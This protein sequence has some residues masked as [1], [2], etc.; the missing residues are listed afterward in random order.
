MS[1]EGKLK[2]MNKMKRIF[3]IIFITILPLSL[4]AQAL[5]SIS[6]RVT[7]KK[8]GEVLPGVNVV[9]EKLN[10]GTASMCMAPQQEQ[11]LKGS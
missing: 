8:T 11:C 10:L 5:G 9:I 3:L 4:W 1:A 6:G 2:T 7:D